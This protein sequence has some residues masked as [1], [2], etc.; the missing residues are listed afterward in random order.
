MREHAAALY[1][2][3]EDGAHLYVCGGMRMGDDVHDALVD[4]VGEQSGRGREHAE[5]Y[6]RAL[7]RAGRYVRDV[8]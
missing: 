3:L 1:E 5:E 8:Y 2:W 7:R 6:V 4:V